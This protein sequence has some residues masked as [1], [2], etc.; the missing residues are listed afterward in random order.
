MLSV[1]WTSPSV[2]GGAWPQGVVYVWPQGVVYVHI[3]Q[4]AVRGASEAA[5]CPSE[6]GLGRLYE[7]FFG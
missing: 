6:R 3:L 4:L 5:T 2:V 1:L 7:A